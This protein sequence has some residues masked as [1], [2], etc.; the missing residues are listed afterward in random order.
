MLFSL[1]GR[2]R[3]RS[4]RFGGGRAAGALVLDCQSC[5]VYHLDGLIVLQSQL[6]SLENGVDLHSKR[7]PVQLYLWC[8]QTLGDHI[9]FITHDRKY[10][11]LTIQKELSCVPSALHVS[12]ALPQDVQ[13]IFTKSSKQSQ[14]SCSEAALYASATANRHRQMKSEHLALKAFTASTHSLTYTAVYNASL[15][16]WINGQHMQFECESIRFPTFLP[17]RY[18]LWIRGFLINPNRSA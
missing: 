16:F 5:P 4:G 15:P 2:S 10:R 1:L 17:P 9:H 12:A 11:I 3:F 6:S 8:I 7:S 13:T 14:L 18:S